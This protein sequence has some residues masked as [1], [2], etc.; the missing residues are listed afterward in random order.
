MSND[1]GREYMNQRQAKKR[2][3][4]IV[5]STDIFVLSTVDGR[6]RPQSR[7]MG[8]KLVERGM[9]IY[10]ETYAD[11]AKVKQIRKKPN[12][13]LLFPTKD[14]S[15]VVTLSGKASIED[16]MALKKRI[17][18]KNPASKDY[19]SGFDDPRLALIKFQPEELK[20]IGPEAGMEVLEMKL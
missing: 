1:Q 11:S 16:S 9:T 3:L 13:Q 6:G 10:M 2:A 4:E 17:W 18:A 15:E 12:A 5:N 7:F 19:F 20:Y 14:Y 8:A